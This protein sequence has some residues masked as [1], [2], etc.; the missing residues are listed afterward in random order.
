MPTGYIDIIKSDECN[1]QDPWINGDGM[2]AIRETFVAICTTNMPP[3]VPLLRVWLSPCLGRTEY[4]ADDA[5]GGD[6]D[7]GEKASRKSRYYSNITKRSASRASRKSQVLH[8]KT[9][10]D[11][12]FADLEAPGP[13]EQ[14]DIS[15]QTYAM[16]RGGDEAPATGT[17]S[18]AEKS[19]GYAVTTGE[20][21]AATP[22]QRSPE[23]LRGN[24]K[25]TRQRELVDESVVQTTREIV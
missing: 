23:R 14:D 17:K 16:S 11:R 8:N 9:M 21:R 25:N 18:S 12:Y 7:G 1:E 10:S 3:I 24:D 5:D 13:G 19:I 6:G 22:E 4:A 15:L 2:W 20:E